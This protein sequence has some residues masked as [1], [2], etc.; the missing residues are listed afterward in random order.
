MSIVI[1]TA[2]LALVSG[3]GTTAE[4]STAPQTA[5]AQSAAPSQSESPRDAES[6]AKAQRF[7]AEVDAGDWAGSWDVAGD[8]IQS[9]VSVEGWT[10]TV[11]PV[12]E[13]LGAVTSREFSSVQK[14]T[15]LPGAPEGDYEVLQ[16]TTTF[17]NREQT[18]VETVIMIRTD[19]GFD[20]AGFFIR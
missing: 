20:V 19:E 5:S 7:L 8:F 4:T 10:S 12:R 6:Y 3:A 1:A 18:S 14:T 2:V 11:E 17:E 9:Q 15:V 16:F 13:P